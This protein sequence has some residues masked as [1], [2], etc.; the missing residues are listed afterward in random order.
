VIRLHEDSPVSSLALLYYLRSPEG[1]LKVQSLIKGSTAHVYPKDL[2]ELSIPDLTTTA[3]MEL[4]DKLHTEAEASFRKYLAAE[5]EI[6]AIL[7]MDSISE[8]DE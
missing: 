2:V 5:D 1:R 4:I 3:D 6:S 7:G 8:D